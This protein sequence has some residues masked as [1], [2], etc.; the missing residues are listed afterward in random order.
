MAR[1][2][3]ARRGQRANRKWVWQAVVE[4]LER[5]EDD[6]DTPAS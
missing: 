5:E 6:K 1:A 4:R 3:L 2:K